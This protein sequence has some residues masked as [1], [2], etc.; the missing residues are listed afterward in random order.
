MQI[1]DVSEVRDAVAWRFREVLG[2]FKYAFDKKVCQAVSMLRNCTV[3]RELS[4]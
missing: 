2:E 4:E 1:R 3:A